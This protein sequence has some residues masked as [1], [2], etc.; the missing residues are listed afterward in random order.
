MNIKSTTGF[1][2]SNFTVFIP[3]GR[4]IN[5]VT[6]TNWEGTGIT[7]DIELPQE[8]ALKVAHIQALKKVLESISD[9]P[10]GARKMLQEEVQKAQAEL[11]GNSGAEVPSE[12]AV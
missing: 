5:P 7:P 4:A 3:T 11:N 9:N 1:D 12:P 8:Q 2:G 10:T 6:Q